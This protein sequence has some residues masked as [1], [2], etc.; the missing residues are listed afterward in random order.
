MLIYHVTGVGYC[1]VLVAFYT[2]FYYNVIIGWAFYFM[3]ASM[4][5]ELPWLHC[6]NT[7][8]SIFC[9]EGSFKNVSMAFGLQPATNQSTAAMEYFE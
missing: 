5:S 4:S 1:A 3:F 2:S 7:W 9:L 6:N 8:N